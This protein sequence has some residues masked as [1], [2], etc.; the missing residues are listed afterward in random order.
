MTDATY[1]ERRA[2][3]SSKHASRQ[4]KAYLRGFHKHAETWTA[5]ISIMEDDGCLFVEYLTVISQY[6]IGRKDLPLFRPKDG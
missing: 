5:I 1:N 4:V 6:E 2:R 3:I